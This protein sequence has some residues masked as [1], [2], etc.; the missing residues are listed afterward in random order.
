MNT[1]NLP[2]RPLYNSPALTLHEC[3][4][5]HSFQAALALEAPERPDFR[6]ETYFSGYGE[7]WGLYTEW[8][9]IGMGIYRTPSEQ[10][11]RQ[12]YAMWRA[13]TRVID[14]GIH[15]TGWG[16]DKAVDNLAGHPALPQ[17]PVQPQTPR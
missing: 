4:P 1:Y 6:G 11:G 2:V 12:S 17:P 3:A 16:R 13:V 7:G 15:R 9:G 10:F 14:P 8:L 5:G